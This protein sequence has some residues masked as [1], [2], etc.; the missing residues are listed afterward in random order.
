MNEIVEVQDWNTGEPPRLLYRR[1]MVV[2]Y[3]DDHEFGMY[4][5]STGWMVLLDGKWLHEEIKDE[6]IKGWIPLP[7]THN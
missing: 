5:E 4:S 1:L 2:D 3:L 6:Y 7:K